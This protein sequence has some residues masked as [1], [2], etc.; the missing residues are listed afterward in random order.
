MVQRAIDQGM[1]SHET[2]ARRV[3]LARFGRPEE[4]ANL[5]AFLL[6]DDASYITGIEVPIDGGWLAFGAM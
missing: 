6:S 3:P 4:V 1:Q 5:I 2:V